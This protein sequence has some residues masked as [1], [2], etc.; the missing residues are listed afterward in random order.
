MN[1]NEEY[2]KCDNPNSII[3]SVLLIP[4]ILIGLGMEFSGFIKEAIGV[5]LS[6]LIIILLV[7]IFIGY[8][9]YKSILVLINDDWIQLLLT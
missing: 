1:D 9:V 7:I 5:L 6:I 8:L 2:V 3:L 4:A